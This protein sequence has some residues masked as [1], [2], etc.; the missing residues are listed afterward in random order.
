MC[1]SDWSSDVC[2]SDLQEG[3]PEREQEL[4]DE[5]QVIAHRRQRLALDAADI[6][7]EAQQEMERDR[8]R[9]EI[10]QR[11]TRDE[12]HRRRRQERQQRALFLALEPRRHERTEE[13][14]CELQ[15]PSS[16]SYAV[17]SQKK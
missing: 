6:A 8:H 10:G 1:I 2:S 13:H 9:D 3:E 11:R 17:Y 14:T 4:H 5:R 16:T 15:A 12:Q 7:L